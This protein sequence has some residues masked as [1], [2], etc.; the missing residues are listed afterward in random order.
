MIILDYKKLFRV[1]G[2]ALL[3]GFS[4]ASAAVNFP[5]PRAETVPYAHGIQK[6]TGTSAKAA[7]VQRNF[8]EWQDTFYV[9]GLCGTDSCARI[10]FDD[11]SYTV[12]EG[13]GYG[14]LIMVLM[15]NDA[16]D[17]RAKFDRLWTYY[18]AFAD[19]QGLMNW[20]IQGFSQVNGSGAA[21]D[22]ELD[23]ALALMLAY[24]QWG[25]TSYL[26]DARSMVDKIYQYEVDANGYLM[27]GDGWNSAKNPSYQST[28]AMRL[29]DS[30]PGQDGRWAKVV[31]KSYA[32]LLRNT[33]TVN[34]GTGLPSDWCDTSG[35]AVAGTAETTGVFGYESVRTPWRMS[36]AYAWFGDT[37]ARNVAGKIAA[38]ANDSR[39]SIAGKVGNLLDGYHVKDGTVFHSTNYEP[40]YTAVFTGAFGV[41]G[42]VDTTYSAW[43]DSCYDTLSTSTTGGWYYDKTLQ[44][45]YGIV[46]S[47]NFSNLWALPSASGI[48]AGTRSVSGMLQVRQ[49]GALLQVSLPG[50]VLC[51]GEMYSLSGRRVASLAPMDGGLACGRA[52]ISAGVYQIRVVAADG[53]VRSGRLLLQ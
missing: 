17:T 5:F 42:L 33:S 18:K 9:E 26:A 36:M 27:P 1:G 32:L 2:A 40:S 13:I 15:D 31:E 21:T 11:R 16:N 24:R 3:L 44:V 8:T 52:R 38:F 35:A 45:L 30:L 41:A 46:L 50:N 25:D 49:Q 51:S 43:V 28:M 19:A 23:V 4:G 6:A 39:Y 29:F 53:S 7:E 22:A 20:K 10:R 12:S 34:S 14:M 48:S 47:G 37:A